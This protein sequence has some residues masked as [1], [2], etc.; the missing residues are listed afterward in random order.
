MHGRVRVGRVAIVW[1]AIAC[2][3]GA[4]VPG[5]AA[6]QP[7]PGGTGTR[8]RPVVR[9]N[10]PNNSRQVASQFGECVVKKHRWQAVQWLESRTSEQ[11]AKLQPQIFDADCLDKEVEARD[12]SIELTLPGEI[13]KFAIAEPL[14]RDAIEGID[15]AALS[16]APRLTYLAPDPA[17]FSPKGKKPTAK[18]I[19]DAEKSRQEATLDLAFEVYGECVVRQNPF[20]A[21]QLLT[22][23]VSSS[24]EANAFGALMPSFSGCLPKNQQFTATRAMLRGTV[25][26]AYY[27]LSKAAQE[28]PQ[29]AK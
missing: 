24:A 28:Q 12:A 9:H 5:V 14:A 1:L 27:R 29:S 10:P 11:R 3:I 26:L 15:P 19:A 18:Q 4:L 22:S 17:V 23:P 8:I 16:K 2:M 13:A 25:A 6:G 7:A 21:R 20:A